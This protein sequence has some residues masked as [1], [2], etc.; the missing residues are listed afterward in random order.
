MLSRSPKPE[1]LQLLFQHLPTLAQ[2][3]S[4][5][6]QD[7]HQ[8]GR[9][10]SASGHSATTNGKDDVYKGQCDQ[11]NGHYQPVA[12]GHKLNNGNQHEVNGHSNTDSSD[13]QQYLEHSGSSNSDQSNGEEDGASTQQPALQVDGQANGV[14]KGKAYQQAVELQDLLQDEVE[15]YLDKRHI[16]DILH[17]FSGSHPPL[18]S[19]LSCLRP[20]QPRLYS[21][22]S[23]QREHP[24]RVQITVAVV[25]YRALGRDRIGVTSTFLKE[26]MQVCKPYCWLCPRGWLCA[27]C[28]DL[29]A[30]SL[31]LQPVACATRQCGGTL[32]Q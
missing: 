20:L 30:G 11:L 14:S 6:Q 7:G 4:R 26:R 8:K 29:P 3:A 21:I 22:S 2:D 32:C 28:T 19:L 18:A 23:S 25:R 13:R 1:L 16:I 15:A 17:D 5:S 10:P 27:H 24:K 31:G 9:P 12:N